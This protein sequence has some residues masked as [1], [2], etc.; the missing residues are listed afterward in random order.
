VGRLIGRFGDA[1]RT[2]DGAWPDYAKRVGSLFLR[3]FAKIKGGKTASMATRTRTVTVPLEKMLAT[4][5]PFDFVQRMRDLSAYMTRLRVQSYFFLNYLYLDALDRRDT[6]P[7]LPTEDLFK[8]A[9]ILCRG[10]SS[11]TTRPELLA[12][13]TTF[14]KETGLQPE[15]PPHEMIGLDQPLT[16]EARSMR[17]SVLRLYNDDTFEKRRLPCLRFRI[18]DAALFTGSPLHRL[19]PKTFS[20]RVH[21]LLTHIAQAAHHRRD[22]FILCVREIGFECCGEALLRVY[23]REVRDADAWRPV[24]TDF[25]E[26]VVE[27]EEGDEST[28]SNK[29]VLL[30][31]AAMPR[32]AL[33]LHRLQVDYVVDE[34]LGYEAAW[35]EARQAGGTKKEIRKAAEAKRP[36]LG[37]LKPPTMKSPLP[38][39]SNQAVFV[40]LDVKALRKIFSKDPYLKFATEGWGFTSVL[41]AFKSTGKCR[42][43]CLRVD[44]GS[45]ESVKSMMEVLEQA[46]HDPSTK[47]PWMVDATFM[48]DGVQ[49]KLILITLASDHVPLPGFRELAG[50]GY[51]HIST[52]NKIS[53]PEVIRRGKGLYKA[54]AIAGTPADIPTGF[55][56]SANDPG[57]NHVSDM[58]IGT[59]EQLSDRSRAA[60]V[61]ATN[62]FFTG[63]EYRAATLS[64][65]SS[66]AEKL[67]RKR[68]ASYQCALDALRATRKRTPCIDEYIN[69]VRVWQ[70]MKGSLWQE[71]QNVLRRLHRFFRFQA[72]QRALVQL[73]NWMIGDTA[74][75]SILFFGSASFQAQKGKASVPRKALLRELLQRTIVVLV[76][77]AYTSIM[78]PGCLGELKKGEA[79]R[80]KR[81]ET[82]GDAAPCPLH[83]HTSELEMGRD[84]VGG[85]GIGYRGVEIIM[86]RP[87]VERPINLAE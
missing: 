24:L 65:F 61:M 44:G 59:L 12:A 79:Y 39:A 66:D 83:P 8:T 10:S 17:A 71:L 30:L 2:K 32:R 4:T 51:S 58:V 85:T 64:L 63:V 41:N 54:E 50:R 6:E 48:T 25:G 62:R 38:H 73:A 16:F 57:Q 36:R 22:A 45:G 72:T 29:R 7:L 19:R 21:K 55:V 14:V 1:V 77:E 26:D 35:E 75:R 27:D 31:T 5:A 60:E 76:R 69:Y 28:A 18:K 40:R 13:Y 84:N 86:Q 74:G 33:Y 20:R 3:T 81:C 78:C 67:R 52:K 80:T 56:F 47:C 46:R 34:L 43:P 87:V 15:R 11:K 42:I 68:N 37:L 23:D 70:D 9:M 82:V 49:L 53:L